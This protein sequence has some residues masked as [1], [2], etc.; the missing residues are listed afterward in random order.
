MPALSARSE[1]F[2]LMSIE[3]K[4]NLLAVVAAVLALS[5]TLGLRGSV[6]AETAAESVQAN[7]G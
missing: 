1:W 3:E 7:C 6:A 5:S 2:A 4:S